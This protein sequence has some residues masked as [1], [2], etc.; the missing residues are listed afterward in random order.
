MAAS[1]IPKS[2][3]RENRNIIFGYGEVPYITT[4]EGLE[5]WG[6]LGGEITS[7]EKEAFQYAEKLDQQIRA[8]LKHVSQLNSA[9][10]L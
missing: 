5:G 7:S 8:R 6:L 10:P 1:I 3:F 9:K 4:E 2:V